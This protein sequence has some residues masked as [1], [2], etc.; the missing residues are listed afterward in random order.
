MMAFES[1]SIAFHPGGLELFGMTG[2]IQSMPCASSTPTNL[3]AGVSVQRTYM[4]V[5]AC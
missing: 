2:F 4:L 5:S 3:P 1:C